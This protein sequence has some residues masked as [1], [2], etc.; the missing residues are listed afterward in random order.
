MNFTLNRLASHKEFA[1][2]D[3]DTDFIQRNYEEL[4]PAKVASA[5]PG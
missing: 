4:F 2:G 3:V 1:A 5:A